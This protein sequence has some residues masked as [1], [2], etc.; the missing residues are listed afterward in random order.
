[1]MP[2]YELPRVPVCTIRG[3]RWQ[4]CQIHR[5]L[6]PGGVL[7]FLTGQR[8]VE[9]LCAKLRAAFPAPGQRRRDPDASHD[10][11]QVRE[12]CCCPT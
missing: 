10:S 4:V 12:C 5:R 7:V 2:I 9:R 6:P 8:E 11:K 3:N 1:M